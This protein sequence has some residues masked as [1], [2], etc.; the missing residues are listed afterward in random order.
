ME[1]PFAEIVFPIPV[2]HGYTYSIPDKFQG[3]VAPGMRVL[4]PFGPRKMTGF[5]V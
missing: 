2:G 1:K 4:A 5:I 3:D